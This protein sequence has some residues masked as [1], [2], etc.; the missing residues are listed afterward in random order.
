[1]DS[2]YP[3]DVLVNLTFSAEKGESPF[4]ICSFGSKNRGNEKRQSYE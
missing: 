3:E 2:L 1:M 4:N